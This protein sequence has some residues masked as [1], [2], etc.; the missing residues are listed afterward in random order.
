MDADGF[1]VLIDFQWSDADL[2][3]NESISLANQP[4]EDFANLTFI[5]PTTAYSAPEMTRPTANPSP[6][7][8]MQADVYSMGKVF[9]EMMTINYANV[10]DGN[11]A[12]A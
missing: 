2:A 1:L 12:M 4:Q 7:E 3:G 10:S 6:Q 5:S 9:Q 8:R 11:C